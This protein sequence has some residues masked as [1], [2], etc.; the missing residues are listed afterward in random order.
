MRC[1]VDG[2]YFIHRIQWLVAISCII[3]YTYIA[4]LSGKP[5]NT[6]KPPEM[7]KDLIRRWTSNSIEY[8]EPM[9]RPM[10]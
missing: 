6:C 8:D 1:K 9:V 7:E 4:I 3:E 2:I 10:G 5:K